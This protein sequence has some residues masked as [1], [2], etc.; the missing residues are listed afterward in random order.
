MANIDINPN[1]IVLDYEGMQK[2]REFYS[3]AYD[4]TLQQGSRI[5][6]FRNVLY[7]SPAV[8]I[9]AAGKGQ[10]KFYTSDFPG[11]YIG[12]INGLTKDGVPGTTS[13]T[14]QVK[15]K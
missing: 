8:N 12:I 13:F 1:A 2:Q 15:E 14:F 11:T 6:D 10:L 7:W 9:N 5:P 3:P 4:T